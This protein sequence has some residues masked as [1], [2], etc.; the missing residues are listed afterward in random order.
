MARASGNIASNSGLSLHTLSDHVC[1]FAVLQVHL[2]GVRAGAAG[3]H[4][5]EKDYSY[6]LPP[7]GSVLAPLIIPRSICGD[8]P[9]RGHCLK[10]HVHQVTNRSL[11][12]SSL[13]GCIFSPCLFTLLLIGL[14]M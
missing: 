13:P 11:D 14:L 6:E 10:V 9:A 12:W 8:P 4:A 5:D 1:E 7:V 2:P 3:F